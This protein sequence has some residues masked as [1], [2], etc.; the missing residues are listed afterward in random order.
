MSRDLVDDIG[1][2]LL[3]GPE[4]VSYVRDEASAGRLYLELDRQLARPGLTNSQAQDTRKAMRE[5]QDRFPDAKH[6]ALTGSPDELGGGSLPPG[7][8]RHQLAQ[9]K[10][11]GLTSQDAAGARRR[12]QGASTRTST[13][14]ARKASRA[15]S[16]AADV[17]TDILSSAAQPAKGA[18]SL[19]ITALGATVALSVLYA[20]VR[21]PQAATTLGAA[22][23]TGLNVFIRP[24][25]PLDPKAKAKAA[26]GARQAQ[27][28]ATV[29]AVANT[30]TS[31]P[32]TVY[33]VTGAN[34]FPTPSTARRP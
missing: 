15:T 7:L 16:A 4:D 2:P 3:L 26:A 29:R 19:V 34:G 6:V 8:R 21:A 11:E 27:A 25:D 20:L 28:R 22:V 32:T 1:A 18:G 9:R 17:G 30:P 13:R 5:L 12:R 31:Q 24:V 10:R 33:P 23:T 14:A